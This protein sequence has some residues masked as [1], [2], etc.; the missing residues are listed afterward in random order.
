MRSASKIINLFRTGNKIF[1]F[2]QKC[3]GSA[4]FITML[5]VVI[6]S[7]LAGSLSSLSIQNASNFY[8]QEKAQKAFFLAEAGANEAVALLKEDFDYK[9]DD[10]NFP[11]TALGEGSYDVTIIET[12]GFVVIRSVGTV[13]GISRDVSITVAD[14]SANDA[15]NFAFF[16]NGDMT[17]QGNPDVTGDIHSNQTVNIT[18]NPTVSGTASASEVVNIT[19]TPILGATQ[20]GAPVIPFPAFDFNF[21]YNLADP[22]DRYAGNQNWAG[23]QTLTPANGVIYVDGDIRISGN[24]NITGAIVV[25]GSITINGNVTQTGITGLPLLMSRDSYIRINGNILD[26]DGLMY[27]GS[28]DIQIYGNINMTGQIIAYDELVITG[29]PSVT[30]GSDISFGLEGDT[31]E[32]FRVISYQE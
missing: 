9:D 32:G 2:S 19:G 14:D 15:F 4:L 21:Y 13:R 7:L 26:A 16:S 8:F 3:E 18:G 30:Q 5:A 31:G 20:D 24:L 10:S 12:G 25:T 27:S 6:I 17:I 29:N 23:N 1:A 22:G 11:L 28:N